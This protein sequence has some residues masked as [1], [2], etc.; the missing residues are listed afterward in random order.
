MEKNTKILLVVLVIVVLIGV[1]IAYSS[2]NVYYNPNNSQITNKNTNTSYSTYD[3]NKNTTSSSN[4]YDT[5]KS[6]TYNTYDTSKSTTSSYS[7]YDTNRNTTSMSSGC[8]F[9]YSNGTK[10]GRAVGT[11]SPLCDYHFNQL[12]DT[13]NSLVG[14]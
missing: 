14:R 2:G 10:C 11:H 3:T 8:Q 6:S 9:K 4:M 7:T 12:N 13:Y 5:S 1:C